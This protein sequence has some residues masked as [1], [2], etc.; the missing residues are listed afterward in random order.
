MYGAQRAAYF[1]AWDRAPSAV[2]AKESLSETAAARLWDSLGLLHLEPADDVP[3]SDSFLLA[4]AFNCYKGPD[5]DRQVINRR[6]RNW[7]ESRL[8][9]HSLFIPVGPMLGMLEINPRRQTL[10]CAATDGK[11][12]YHQLAVSRSKAASNA[13][14]PA[15]PKS[16]CRVNHCFC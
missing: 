11:D 2:C 16:L 7:V 14:G 1:A 10:L 4:K 12:F 13:L 9:G 6:G 3:A 15:L 8:C 5:K